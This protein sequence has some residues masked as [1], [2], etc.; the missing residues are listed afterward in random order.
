[1]ILA[2]YTF[3]PPLEKVEPKIYNKILPFGS[4][5]SKGGKGGKGSKNNIYIVYQ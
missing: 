1:M 5:F 2:L 4:T 3:Y